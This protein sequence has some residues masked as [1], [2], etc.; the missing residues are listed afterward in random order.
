MKHPHE[1]TLQSNFTEHLN[2]NVFYLYSQKK[3]ENTLQYLPK[4]SSYH[5]YLTETT[6][7]LNVLLQVIKE[8]Q[9]LE[10]NQ[11]YVYHVERGLYQ[12]DVLWKFKFHNKENR[13]KAFSY[14]KRKKIEKGQEL[15]YH[16]FMGFL[17]REESSE[18]QIPKS[19]EEIKDLWKKTGN[20]KYLSF[21]YHSTKSA[22]QKQQVSSKTKLIDELLN[23]KGLN[24]KGE[25]LSRELCFRHFLIYV[26]YISN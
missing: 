12:F 15:R 1:A 17:F 25:S 21:L 7:R 18:I 22:L 3:M 23:I 10:C 2:L 4:D 14:F 19:L 5:Y 8:E 11:M 9:L 20:F 13:D 6:N 26:L 24:D 16:S